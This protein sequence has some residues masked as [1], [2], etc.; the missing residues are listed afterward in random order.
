M[1]FLFQG[2]VTGQQSFL[3]NKVL[4]PVER[5]VC[6]PCRHLLK[7]LGLRLG[8][9]EDQLPAIQENWNI[10]YPKTLNQ[11]FMKETPFIFV[12]LGYLR[13]V[14]GGLLDFS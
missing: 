6:A 2:L 3:G 1:I 5:Y 9:V 7:D 12:F 10:P 13:H 11:L 8:E 4:S 14:P